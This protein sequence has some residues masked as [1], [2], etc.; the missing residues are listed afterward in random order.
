MNKCI[1]YKASVCE[2]L[3][4]ASQRQ[5]VWPQSLEMMADS[6]QCPVMFDEKAPKR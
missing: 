3:T 5:R 4:S 2:V 1:V 6:M